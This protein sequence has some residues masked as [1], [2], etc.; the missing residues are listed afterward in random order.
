VGLD[1]FGDLIAIGRGAHGVNAF[2][3]S[4]FKTRYNRILL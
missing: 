1:V 3:Y 2:G 4:R